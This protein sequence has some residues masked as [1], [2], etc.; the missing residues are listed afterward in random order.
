MDK[1][2]KYIISKKY[3]FICYEI[4]KSGI[5]TLRGY[6]INKPAEDYQISH[7]SGKTVPIEVT[8][9][10]NSGFFKF[11][12]VRNPWA[13]MV[14]CWL[15]KFYYYEH[16]KLPVGIDHPELDKSTTFEEFV[17]FAARISDK[18][19]DFHFRSMHVSIPEDCF[20]GNIENFDKDFTIIRNKLGMQIYPYARRNTTYDKKETKPW[21]EY[22]TP[23]LVDIVS[24]RYEEDIK[25]FGYSYD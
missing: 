14:S 2:Y 4:A 3:K 9:A 15:N 20:V 12:F 21:R 16:P 17:K 6:F 18:D 22:Y 8:R 7:V 23:E 1:S 19:A 24:Q 11:A 10:E 5:G 13:R 25:R